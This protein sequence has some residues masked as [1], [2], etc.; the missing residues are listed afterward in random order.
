MHRVSNLEA[1]LAWVLESG[2]GFG[3]GSIGAIAVVPVV[4][5]EQGTHKH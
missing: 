4:V 5:T 2:T 3:K 1:P